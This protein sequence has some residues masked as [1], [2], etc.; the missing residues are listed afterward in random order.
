MAQ[1]VCYYDGSQWRSVGSRIEGGTVYKLLLDGGSLYIGG[2]FRLA[3]ETGDR[4]LCRLHDGAWQS[5]GDLDGRVK[6]L[7]VLGDYL[8][9]GGDFVAVDGFSY[10]HIARFH[11]LTGV[12]ARIGGGLDGSVASLTRVGYCLYIGG[13]FLNPFPSST[14]ICLGQS[15]FESLSTHGLQGNVL[16]ILSLQGVAAVN[17]T[18]VLDSMALSLNQCA[19]T[20]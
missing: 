5:L 20:S 12:W 6:A 2:A 11:V 18:S 9:V 1:D 3:G 8:Y 15:A 14:K 7:A 19:A 16:S 10:P 17:K 13:S 4:N